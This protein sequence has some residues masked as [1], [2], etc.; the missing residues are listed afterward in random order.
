MKRLNEATTLA[1]LHKIYL[2]LVKQN[3]PDLYPEKEEQFKEL[4][5]QY[6]A[7]QKD[8][9]KKNNF[10]TCSC[11]CR[12]SLMEF[13]HGTVRYIHLTKNKFRG[14]IVIDAGTA[15]SN[16]IIFEEHNIII[17]LKIIVDLP[18]DSYQIQFNKLIKT[19]KVSFLKLF[20]GGEV[21][22]KVPDGIMIRVII[23]KRTKS[24]AIFEIPN[25]GLANKYGRDSLYL[26]IA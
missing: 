12:I 4:Q 17:H 24:N 15:L 9:L 11:V 6:K 21:K 19:I 26:K 14:K 5:V 20:F 3:H 16:I 18:D 25:L 10:K 13:I 23:P 2:E 8:I 22:I 7:A 1:S